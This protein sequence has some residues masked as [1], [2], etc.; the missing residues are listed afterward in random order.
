MD[1]SAP[2]TN[3]AA[4]APQAYEVVI[5]VPTLGRPLPWLAALASARIPCRL[6]QH[7]G[8]WEL[9]VPVPYAR[10]ARRE[11]EEYE[12]RNRNWPPPPPQPAPLPFLNP[13]A[14]S[15]SLLVALLLLAF[16]FV[17]GAADEAK[18]VLAAG[19][20]DAERIINGEWWRCLTALTLHADA[21]HVG[22]NAVCAFLFG[23]ALC[24]SVGGG[25]GWLA[26]LLT[27]A[28][29][30][31]IAACW[32]D[33]YRSAVGAS[34][35]TFGALGILAMLQ[36][37][38]N[39]VGLRELRSVWS[40]AWLAILAAVAALGLLGTSPRAD[41]YGHLY[42]FACG[43]G[44]GVVLLPVMDRRLPTWVQTVCGVLCFAAV[45]CAWRLAI[46]QA[47]PGR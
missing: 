18:P 17:V 4:E 6:E 44:I 40:R 19:A 39:F 20:A 16:F 10:R 21:A 41:L 37:R 28:Y 23:Q 25:L 3:P 8:R 46:S 7:E 27:G 47:A 31:L 33:P 38:R 13:E 42:G 26:I 24:R 35:A 15:L 30:N 5:V 45:S 29:G 36:F 9:L 12:R 43:L 22:G 34:T 11:L 14:V 32:G 2:N 1:D